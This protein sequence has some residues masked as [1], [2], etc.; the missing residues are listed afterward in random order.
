[1]TDEADLDLSIDTDKGP[2]ADSNAT[3]WRRWKVLG[4]AGSTLQLLGLLGWTY[5]KWSRYTLG[6]DFATFDQAWTRI[7]TG[8]L[9]PYSSVNPY[10]YPHY[11]YPFIRNHFELIMWP[12]SLLHVLWGSSFVLLAV[13]DIS[14]AGI[15][16]VT[17]LWILNLLRDRWSRLYGFRMAVPIAVLAALLINPYSYETV[18]FDFHLQAPA[19]L[20]LVLAARDLSRGR[21][22]QAIIFAVV[23]LSCGGPVS[24][25]VVGVG[26]AAAATRTPRWPGGAVAALGAAW[27]LT[28]GAFDVDIGSH[29]GTHYG[30]LI[31]RPNGSDTLSAF[32]LAGGIL[33][34]PATTLHVLRV[35]SY[36]IYRYIASSGGLGVLSPW[37]LFLAAVV[38]IP[39]A[40]NSNPYFISDK[41]GF[42]SLAAIPFVFVGTVS[43]WLWISRRIPRGASLAAL[44][45]VGAQI[46]FIAVSVL[47]Q[48]SAQWPILSGSDAAT[49]RQVH[50]ASSAEVVASI[51]VIGRYGGREWVYP[52]FQAT[53]IVPVKRAD[54][55]FIL[56]DD[57]QHTQFL[58]T[59]L[60][61]TVVGHSAHIDIVDWRPPDGLTDITIQPAST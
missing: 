21:T 28:V 50:I 56:K 60:G 15:V 30:Y 45:V 36:H 54:I 4:L 9:D 52:V 12:L 20:F 10:Y 19:V 17:Y 34:H 11:G 46:G 2:D 42:Q 59:Q 26:L 14:V 7:G 18:S 55:V 23:T 57:P 8:H 53:Q 39:N 47:S 22:V 58:T 33:A 31:G 44:G 35:R 61:A 49:L 6:Q 48:F 27:L 24:L 25:Y 43:F 16:L 29:I 38:L 3:D 40:L 41:T 5:F 32:A 51:G 1:M 13:Q 37:G